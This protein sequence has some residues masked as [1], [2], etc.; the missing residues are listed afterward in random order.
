M[1]VTDSLHKQSSE[2]MEFQK[3]SNNIKRR[4]MLYSFWEKIDW[5]FVSF[6]SLITFAC[7]MLR[8]KGS[9]TQS[10]LFNFINDFSF[11]SSF[12]Y[13]DRVF[14]LNLKNVTLTGC[15][16]SLNNTF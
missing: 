5:S 16:V 8:I 9:H 14:K 4:S 1:T 10:L 13:R 2:F 6:G 11:F 12:F 7:D 3:I 15:E